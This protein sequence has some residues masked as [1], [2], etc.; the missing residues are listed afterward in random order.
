M[1]DKAYTE[2]EVAKIIK[3][4]AELESENESVDT[5][6]ENYPHLSLQELETIATEAGLDPKNIRKAALELEPGYSSSSADSTEDEVYAEARVQG[7]LTEELSDLVISDLNHRFNTSHKRKSWRE[8]ILDDGTPDSS[9]KSVVTK[10]GNS[11]EWKYKN[12]KGFIATRVLLQPLRDQI[13]IRVSTKKT[14]GN[15]FSD[16]KNPSN[17]FLSYLPYLVGLVVL[18]SLPFSILI[19]MIAGILSFAAVQ[20]FILP[21]AKKI[22]ALRDKSL[23]GSEKKKTQSESLKR[24]AEVLARDLSQLLSKNSPEHQDTNPDK[25]KLPDDSLPDRENPGRSNPGLRERE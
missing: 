10:T 8:D 9:G 23:P 24:E 20:L 25:I 3:R 6:P 1:P 16:L 19:N 13:R 5:N 15:R 22:P 17:G 11:L 2:K 7:P 12:D 14:A 18:F 21:L 4:A